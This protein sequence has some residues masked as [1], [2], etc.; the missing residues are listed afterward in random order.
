MLP[1]LFAATVVLL[2]WLL[3][4]GRGLEQQSRH[5]FVLLNYNVRF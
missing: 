3:G 2:F 5:A 1:D 4:G